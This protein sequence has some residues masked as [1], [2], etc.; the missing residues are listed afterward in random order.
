MRFGIEST[1]FR[2]QGDVSRVSALKRRPIPPDARIKPRRASRMDAGGD[3]ERRR[4]HRPVAQ[5][6]GEIKS[7]LAAHG[8]RPKHR[9]G[10]NFL[11]DANQMRRIMEAAELREG[12]LVLEVGPGTGALTERLLEGGAHVVAVEVDRDL[13]PILRERLADHGDR[14]TLIVEDVLAGKH[15]LNPRVVEAVRD[16]DFKLI[17]NLPYNVAS[18]LLVNLA[19]GFPRMSL[20]LVMVQREVADRLAAPHGGK[21]YGPL[22]VMVQ[23]MCTVERVATLA[24][25]CFWPAPDVHSA[26]AKLTRRATPL[27]DDPARLAEMLHTLFSKRRKQ[28]GSVLGRDFPF[29]AGIA[30]DARPEQLSVEQHVALSRVVR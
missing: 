6:L 11:H 9:F 18:P 30:A 12:E 19:I 13:E 10:Q 20:A 27:T 26:V 8:L 21:D 15:E 23:A 16:R 29:P 25:G 4:Y 5:T 22:S 2:F 24:P 3:A 14:F 28:L 1:R 7:L 17:A